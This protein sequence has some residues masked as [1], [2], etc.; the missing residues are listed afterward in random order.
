[1]NPRPPA[2]C[3]HFP[4]ASAPPGLRF[5]MG[6]LCVRI[7][8]VPYFTDWLFS[9]GGYFGLESAAPLPQSAGLEH[10]PPKCCPSVRQRLEMESPPESSF[11]AVGSSL[12]G[13]E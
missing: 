11:P 8:K 6:V 9:R 3:G 1:M 10:G 5:V 4:H 12:L 13:G 7:F 2:Q